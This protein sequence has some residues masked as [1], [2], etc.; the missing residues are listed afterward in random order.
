M[1]SAVSGIAVCYLSLPFDN[2]KTKMMKMRPNKEGILPYSGLIDC[3]RKTVAREGLSSLW[4]G[5]FT[6]YGRVAPHAMLSLLIQDWLHD[7]FT[8]KR[9]NKP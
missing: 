6:Y 3:F 8:H 2:A 4:V 7:I 9:A 1:S 5:S